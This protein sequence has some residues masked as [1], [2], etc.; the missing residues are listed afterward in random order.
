MAGRIGF[1]STRPA[2]K[3]DRCAAQGQATAPIRR[4]GGDRMVI[5][6]AEAAPMVLYI[7]KNG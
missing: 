6:A 7:A 3:G 5:K 4:G 2:V 1:G